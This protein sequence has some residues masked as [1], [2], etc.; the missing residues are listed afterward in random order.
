MTD[1]KTCIQEI[2]DKVKQFQAERGWI[3]QHSPKNLAM[4][5]AVEAAEIMEI[6]QFV[7]TEAAWDVARSDEAEHVREELADVLIYCMSFANALDI[8]VAAAVQDKLE[9]NRRRWPVKAKTS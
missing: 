3:A 9:K 4:S 7:T 8:D 2:K 6:F 5:I 1:T